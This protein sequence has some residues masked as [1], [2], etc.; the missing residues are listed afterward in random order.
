MNTMGNGADRTAFVLLLLFLLSMYSV[1]TELVPGTAALRPA[2][3]LGVGALA[4]FLLNRAFTRRP[5]VVPWPEGHALFAFFGAASLSVF[6]AL[7]PRFA[8]YR[9]IE[10]GKLLIIY[11]LMVNVVTTR[12]RLRVL[13][14]TMVIGGTMPAIGTVNNY[15]IGNVVENRAAWLGRFAGPNEVAFELTI[16]IPLAISL[17]LTARWWGRLILGAAVLAYLSAVLVT[18][19]RSGI[20]GLAAMV[21]VAL[22]R[23][24]RPLVRVL[25]VAFVVLGVIVG[26]QLWERDEGFD[27]LQQD[28]TF[29]QRFVTV[30]TG[31]AMFQS[32][33][34]FGIGIGCSA[35]GWM[36]FSPDPY[37]IEGDTLMIHNTFIQVLAETGL[38]GF[39]TFIFAIGAALWKAYKLESGGSGDREL[40][41]YA[42]AVELSFVAFFVCSLAN[43]F[44]EIAAPYL[45][46]GLASTTRMLAAAEAEKGTG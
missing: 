35:T 7:W 12:S 42:L 30:A 16:L 34:L 36:E 27:E 18:F 46:V 4:L 37:V 28:S 10:L 40:R 8:V 17:M 43:G 31:L 29:G 21:V 13:I 11:V 45:L 32:N 1:V 24:R 26:S 15:L 5:V 3:I 6:T 9:G 38:L 25:I 2:L 44:V 39:V 22:L 33:P 19:S 41:G 14:W 23:A 20:L